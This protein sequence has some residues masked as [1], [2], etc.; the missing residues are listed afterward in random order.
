MT[1][2]FSQYYNKLGD[3][4]SPVLT[5]GRNPSLQTGKARLIWSQPEEYDFLSA[6]V[7]ATIVSDSTDDSISGIG[8]RTVSITYLSEDYFQHTEVVSMNGTTPVNLPFSI[9]RVN[10]VT[11]VTAGSRLTNDGEITVS[12][13][14]AVICAVID[15]NM[16]TTFQSVYTIPADFKEG[17]LTSA[18]LDV[19][20]MG[21]PNA[22][23]ECF[24]YT[25]T[26]G[27]AVIAQFPAAMTRDA[28]QWDIVGITGSSI[29]SRTDIFW[30]GES[31]VQS[32]NVVSGF[33]LLLVK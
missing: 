22:E 14:G 32:A 23:V 19:R 13:G 17:I 21:N 25:R 9:F 8:A 15:P 10:D 30:T 5:L 24:L 1:F 4:F 2:P 12:D 3:E 33:G 16:G 6:E 20:T 11:V 18:Y 29:P 31:F 28:P 27:G 7:N 26:A